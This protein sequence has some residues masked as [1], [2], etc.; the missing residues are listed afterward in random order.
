MNET[1]QIDEAGLTPLATLISALDLQM[2]LGRISPRVFTETE[3]ELAALL[4][5]AAVYDLGYLTRIRITGEDRVRWLNGMVTNTVQALPQGYGN[6]TLILNA[7]GRIQGDGYVYRAA[8]HILFETD[9]AQAPRLLAH[10]DHFII[11]DDV[12]LLEL[13]AETTTLGLAG[14]QAPGILES[15]NLPIP[16]TMGFV[17][18]ELQGIPITIVN[19]YSVLVPR[20]EIWLD[21]KDIA[22]VWRILTEVGATLAG[23][24]ALESLRILEATPLYGVDM[25]DR[26]LPQETNLTRALNFNKGCYLGQEIVERIRSRATVHRTLHQFELNGPLPAPGAELRAEGDDKAIGGLTSAAHYALPGLP[27]TFAIGMVRI[28]ALERKAVITYPGGQAVPLDAPPAL[29]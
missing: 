2:H 26:Y 29:P 28:E 6:Y 22:E 23:F 14:P 17:T 20:F 13:D 4:H 10:L 8:D 25:G 24:A 18:A 7:Q 1:P 21:A 9:R 27:R 16:E 11:M 5:S 3:S 19:A 12:E 15:L